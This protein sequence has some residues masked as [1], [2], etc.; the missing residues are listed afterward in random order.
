MELAVPQDGQMKS[1][2]CWV[3]SAR[4]R[5]M[6]YY[7]AAQQLAQSRAV[8]A[9]KG[10]ADIDENGSTSE[11]ISAIEF[12]T[13]GS[14][15]TFDFVSY[16]ER[17]Y[18][19]DALVQILDD[20]GP[21]IVCTY[22]YS[23]TS[24]ASSFYSGH[25]IL[26]YGYAVLNGEYRFLVHDPLPV[27]LGQSYMISYDKLYSGTEKDDDITVITGTDTDSN[28]DPRIWHSIVVLNT[29][30]TAETRPYYFGT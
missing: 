30:C 13:D 6:Y 10:D 5:S 12:F 11:I 26:I 7:P 18:S 15:V 24:D 20:G 29:T 16:E 4:M 14:N 17:T 25:A 3:T 27:R 23:D 1:R 21:V 19:E 22:K 9:I 8:E 2:W 28:N